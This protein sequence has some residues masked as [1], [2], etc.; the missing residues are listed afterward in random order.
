[1]TD[2]QIMMRIKSVLGSIIMYCI[3]VWCDDGTHLIFL[4]TFIL[5][6]DLTFFI[7]DC[8]TLSVIHC[9]ANLK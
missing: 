4:L 9:V 5:I 6:T 2:S 8:L 1:M 3:V 7:L